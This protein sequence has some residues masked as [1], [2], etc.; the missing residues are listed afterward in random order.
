MLKELKS[1]KKLPLRVFLSLI[2]C[3]QLLSSQIFLFVLR[4]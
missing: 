2:H 3:S 1:K 4:F